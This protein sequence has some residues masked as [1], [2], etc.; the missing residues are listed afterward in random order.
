M[1]STPKGRNEKGQFRNKHASF[2]VAVRRLVPCGPSDD[3][4]D[5]FAG[6]GLMFR[7]CWRHAGRGATCDLET[8]CVERAVPERPFWTVLEINAEKALRAGLWRERPFSIVDLD[9]YG[10][11]WRFLAAF[12]STRR[13]LANPCRLVLTD[14]YM[15]NRNLSHEDRTLGYRKPGTPED[16]LRCVDELLQKTAAAQGW[17]CSR[18]LYRDG[19]AVQHLVT[20][21]RAG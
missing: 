2:K 21:S 1:P 7:H 3:V 6:D 17:S 15:G 11:P 19:K 4:L 18:K 13:A 5:V 14:H 9:C 8:N 12:F 10:S 16:Y 20:L